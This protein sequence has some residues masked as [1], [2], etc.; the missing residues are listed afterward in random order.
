M[1]SGDV[2]EYF[3]DSCSEQ[4]SIHDDRFVGTIKV[5][6][7]ERDFWFLGSDVEF[8][9]D[10]LL[11]EDSVGTPQLP[12]CQV[13]TAD[14]ISKKMFEIIHDVNAVFQVSPPATCVPSRRC[15]F[16]FQ[17]RTSEYCSPHASGTRRNYSKGDCGR[18]RG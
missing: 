7:G 10:G 15:L 18:G 5:C 9:G 3:Y 14:D 4:D 6:R 1:A 11:R 16:S 17:N 2:Q 12:T 13:L 8:I